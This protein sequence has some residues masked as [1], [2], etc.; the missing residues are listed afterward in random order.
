MRGRNDWNGPLIPGVVIMNLADRG[1][2]LRVKWKFRILPH[3]F[4]IRK[5]PVASQWV[6]FLQ[7]H[8]LF[9]FLLQAFALI[10]LRTIMNLHLKL[11]HS[12]FR[13]DKGTKQAALL[14]KGQIRSNSANLSLRDS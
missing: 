3:K 4:D 11:I 6:G 10:I 14:L 8:I 12:S 9:L 1:D 13:G 7:S 2:L 5:G